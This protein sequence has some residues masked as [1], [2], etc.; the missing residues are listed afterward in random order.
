MVA[1]GSGTLGTRRVLLYERFYLVGHRTVH[2]FCPRGDL[3][4][5]LSV[6]VIGRGPQRGV[7]AGGE[8]QSDEIKYVVPRT[9]IG[10]ARPFGGTVHQRDVFVRRG[11]RA[12]LPPSRGHRE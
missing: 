6:L 9:R 1:V 10:L 11:G 12:R 7:I 5:E 8:E 2:P 4:R 3:C